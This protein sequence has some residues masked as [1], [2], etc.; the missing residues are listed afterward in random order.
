[1]RTVFRFAS[2]LALASIAVVAPSAVTVTVENGGLTVVRPLTGSI[3]ATLRIRVDSDDPTDTYTPTYGLVVPRMV[4]GSGLFAGNYAYSPPQANVN[5]GYEGFYTFVVSSTTALGRYD[6]GNTLAEPA[7]LGVVTPSHRSEFT[8]ANYF[9]EVTASPVPEP[10]SMA[11]LG[12]GV[13]AVLR[14]RKRA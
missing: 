5:T 10:A 8:W 14:R 1:M 13:A 9:V 3:E 4:D 7:R 11:A 12:L 6:R 2:I